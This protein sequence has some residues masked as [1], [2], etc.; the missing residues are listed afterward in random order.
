MKWSSSFCLSHWPLQLPQDLKPFQLRHSAARIRSNLISPLDGVKK[1]YVYKRPKTHQ[2][3]EPFGRTAEVTNSPCRLPQ[4]CQNFQGGLQAGR[5][6]PISLP[7]LLLRLWEPWH[8]WPGRVGTQWDKGT[9]K[10]RSPPTLRFTEDQE[11]SHQ[12]G[13]CLP[14]ARGWG[15]VVSSPTPLE[16]GK[17]ILGCLSRVLGWWGGSFLEPRCGCQMLLYQYLHV[18]LLLPFLLLSSPIFPFCQEM[19]TKH[20]HEKPQHRKGFMEGEGG[21]CREPRGQSASP[22]Q[23]GVETQGWVTG[24]GR[25]TE[26]MSPLNSP[27][28]NP[29]WSQNSLKCGSNGWP[30]HTITYLN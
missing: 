22:Q 15:G 7:A 12:G 13:L 14:L 30:E 27:P 26:P 21:S 5:G 20:L 2:A 11:G 29:P 6:A 17:P 4:P 25:D 28:P 8:Q 23:A 10:G 18:S 24:K 1:V 19:K 3:Q 9:T 16:R